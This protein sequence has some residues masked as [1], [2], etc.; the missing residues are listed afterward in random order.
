MSFKKLIQFKSAILGSKILNIMVLGSRL[1]AALGTSNMGNTMEN[2]ARAVELGQLKL[3]IFWYGKWGLYLFDYVFAF[4][5]INF[6]INSKKN[7]KNKALN[8]I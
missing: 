7:R 3:L 8:L 2:I 4:M 6:F 5:R 1:Y